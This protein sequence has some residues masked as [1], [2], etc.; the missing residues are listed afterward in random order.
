MAAATHTLEEWRSLAEALE[1]SSGMVIGGELVDAASGA[2]F[3]TVN[4]AT[5][6]TLAMVA[7]GDLSL[8]AIDK[9]TGL[10]TTWIKHRP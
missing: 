3:A 10:K 4:P 9:Y 8:H 1:P 5:G 7:A 6:E 2:T